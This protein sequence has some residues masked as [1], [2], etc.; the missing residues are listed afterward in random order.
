MI[1]KKKISLVKSSSSR[2]GYKPLFWSEFSNTKKQKKPKTFKKVQQHPDKNFD[3]DINNIDMDIDMDIDIDYINGMDEQTKRTYQE[4][5]EK[6][7]E[8][9]NL[10]A[11]E[12]ITT[13]IENDLFL[14]N[15]CQK[16]YN[17]AQYKCL[18]CGPS[19]YYCKDCNKAFH[20][21]TNIFHDQ[22]DK[23]FPHKIETK[24]RFL[25]PLCSENCPHPIKNV[26]V[27]CL[28]GKY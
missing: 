10:M 8:N 18:D 19:V 9:W 27:I 20:Q 2:N 28:K 1:K 13:L 7:A 14:E 4:K 22:I 17:P 11:N 24:K 3:I 26:T 16:C 12:I 25:P 6:E 5:Q 21:K 23:S 15:S